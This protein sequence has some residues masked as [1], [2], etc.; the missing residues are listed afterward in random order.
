MSHA[1]N[2]L[3]WCLKKAGKESGGKHRGLIKIDPDLEVAR[4]HV[5][6]AERNLRVTFYLEQ[7]GFTDWC[8]SSLFYVI[9]HCFLAILSK[10]GY[11]SRNQECTFAVIQVLM[12]DG[13]I[14]LK[15]EDVESVT[16]LEVGENESAVSLREK[17]QY[18]TQISLGKEEYS[19]L[20]TLAKT[21]L[22]KTKEIVI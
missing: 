13:M 9:Y 22:D 19:K 1:K 2:K 16:M 14:D 11:E 18:S 15:K 17:Y 4:D 5:Q 10:Y 12:E 20:L 7:G 21:I 6:K 3:E 8:S